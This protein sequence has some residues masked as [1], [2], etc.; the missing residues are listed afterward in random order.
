MWGRRNK[1]EKPP[2]LRLEDLAAGLR[3]ALVTVGAARETCEQAQGDEFVTAWRGLHHTMR[4]EVAALTELLGADASPRLERMAQLTTGELWE[5][6]E[7][8]LVAHVPGTADDM[9]LLRTTLWDRAEAV[10]A[11]LADRLRR[12]AAR[13][14]LRR[15]ADQFDAAVDALGGGTAEDREAA[16]D[17]RRYVN[18]QV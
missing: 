1:K 8:H 10:R 4:T 5:M 2:A 12:P 14:R 9:A 16:A 18:Q 13:E 3:R 6:A 11:D 17:L 7:P 15:M